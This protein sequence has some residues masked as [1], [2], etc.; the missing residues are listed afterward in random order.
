MAP[1]TD[2]VPMNATANITVRPAAASDYPTIWQVA[3]LDDSSV[4][5]GPLLVA[6]L[7]GELVAALSL[8]SGH[9]IADPF[10][11]TIEAVD[12]LRLRASQVARRHALAA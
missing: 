1:G 11:R 5:G 9:A 3:A 12:L 2:N 4:P 8:E 6:E 10:Q 7:E